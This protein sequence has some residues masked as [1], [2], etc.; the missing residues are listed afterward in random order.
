MKIDITK[1]HINRGIGSH[2]TRCPIGLACQDQGLSNLV[3]NR[4][5]MMFYGDGKSKQRIEM[6]DLMLDWIID[7]DIKRDVDP[8]TMQLDLTENTVVML[9]SN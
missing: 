1:D 8:F 4:G 3:I 2:E 7:F 9:G 6:D 5:F